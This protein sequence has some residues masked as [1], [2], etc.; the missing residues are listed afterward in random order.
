M[1]R[2]QLH[3]PETGARYWLRLLAV[4]VF[5]AFTIVGGILTALFLLGYIK[6]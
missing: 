1:T 4:G 6:P 5:Y 3:A 2:R